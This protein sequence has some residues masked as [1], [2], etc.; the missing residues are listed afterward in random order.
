MVREDWLNDFGLNSP[1]TYND[2][3]NMLTLARDEKGATRGYALSSP[4][5]TR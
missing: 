4:D 1:V 3:Y 2:W 5:G